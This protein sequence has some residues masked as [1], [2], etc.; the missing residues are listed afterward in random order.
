MARSLN[1]G[2]FASKMSFRVSKSRATATRYLEALTAS[3]VLEK[4]KLGRENHYL[5]KALVDVL[6]NTPKIKVE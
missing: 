5:N 6:F 1:K 4:H 2:F 3:G